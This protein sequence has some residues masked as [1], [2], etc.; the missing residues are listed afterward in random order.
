MEPKMLAAV[1]FVRSG[2]K[3]AIISSLDKALAAL[4]GKAGTRVIA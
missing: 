1:R 2:G 3:C 4:S